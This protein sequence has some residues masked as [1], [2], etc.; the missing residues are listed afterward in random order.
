MPTLH[1]DCLIVGGGPAG[2]M[3]AWELQRQGYTTALVDHG[4]AH[5]SGPFETV[6]ASTRELWRRMGLS[7][8]LQDGV[9]DDP[10]RHGAIW[11][12]DA[13][14]WRD[15]GE[16]GLLLRR[17]AF[18][19][20]FRDAARAVGATVYHG[21][22]ASRDGAQWRV[23]EDLI[24][25]RHVAYATGRA[26]TPELEKMRTTGPA[27]TAVT[28]VGEPAGEDRNTAMVE[29]VEQGWIWTHCPADGPASAAIMVDRDRLKGQ[30]VEVILRE[31]LA[32]ALGPAGRFRDW[33]VAN[34]N[35]A[36]MGDRGVA[37]QHLLLGDAA[38]TIDPL[39]SQGVE[40]AVSAAGHAA[41]VIA[42]ALEQPE[43][44]PRLCALHSR[45]E[46]GLQAAHRRSA[47]AFY[48]QEQRFGQSPFWR[49]RQADSAQPAAADDRRW[50][51]TPSI[52][53]GRVLMRHGPRYIEA[54]GAIDHDS[55]EEVARIARVPVAPL[56]QLYAEPSTIS[57]AVDAARQEPSLFVL[58]P[59]EVHDA[60]LQLQARGWLQ[61]LS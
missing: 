20:A 33:R 21:V 35:D 36:S 1:V 59:R 17:G 31:L 48:A 29:A 9:T 30:A 11:G 26:A 23:G 47:H 55:G 53:A 25:A 3:L 52:G 12:Q 37:T 18:D 16:A 15:E 27:T 6:L 44:W 61:P 5:Y 4:R 38:A 40:K 28:L 51:L 2:S 24:V 22:R 60:I 58:S 49:R 13:V 57:A 39:A 8:Q 50:Q 32:R 46:L 10:L 43:W 56:L 34:A 45:W 54:D 41:C 7:Q 19:Q 14:L 42:T